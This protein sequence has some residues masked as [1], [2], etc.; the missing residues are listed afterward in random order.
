LANCPPNA[1][2]Y[3]ALSREGGRVDV[4]WAWATEPDEPSLTITWREIGGPRV[5][6]PTHRGFGSR[7]IERSLAHE[8]GG[9]AS[10]A[11]P[12]SGLVCTLRFRP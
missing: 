7:L 1:A 10:L 6:A 11:Y 3:G 9:S 4:S 5:E 12:A 8:L 2:K